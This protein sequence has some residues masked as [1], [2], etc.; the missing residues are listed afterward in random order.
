MGE[1]QHLTPQPKVSL[2][3]DFT[4]FLLITDKDFLFQEY[5]TKGKSTKRIA[6]E[7]GCS[8]STVSTYLYEHGI[9]FREGHTPGERRGQIPFGMK[10]LNGKLVH[11][12]GEQAIIK[13]IQMLRLHGKSFGDLVDWLN[14]NDI[15][16]KN[17]GRWDRPTVYKILKRHVTSPSSINEL[18]VTAS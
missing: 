6:R 13:E 16:S 14:S 9:E 8:R 4:A 12:L 3:I 2:D 11:H 15:R 18:E 5:V 17:G 1:V 7:V 10:L